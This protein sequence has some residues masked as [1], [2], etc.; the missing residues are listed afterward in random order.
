MANF[1]FDVVSD[2]DKAELNNV[3]DQVQREI[4]SRYDFK[5]TPAAIEWLNSDKTGFKITGNGEW[6]IDAILDIVRKKLATRNQSQ[7]LL[8][9][10]AQIVES[11]LKA[12]QDVKFKQGLDQDK[13]KKVTS[14]IRDKFPKVKTQIQGQE[15]RVT[16]SSKDD[17]QAV[18]QTLR[19]ADFDFPLSFTNF[20]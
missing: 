1:S 16:S 5:A 3:F 20:R 8:D 14:L 17:L 4:V 12:S 11:N 2:Y 10:S 15:V 19:A 6:Q 9:T 13:A 18:M 7:K